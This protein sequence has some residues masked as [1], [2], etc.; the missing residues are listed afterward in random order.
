MHGHY[1]AFI[2]APT[3]RGTTAGHNV[4]IDVDVKCD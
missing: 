1:E 4:W 3:E 2:G